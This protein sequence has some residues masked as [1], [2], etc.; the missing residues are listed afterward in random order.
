MEGHRVRLKGSLDDHTYEQRCIRQFLLPA[1]L[2]IIDANPY[3]GAHHGTYTPLLRRA[4]RIEAWSATGTFFVQAL[5]DTP[6]EML[7]VQEI[8]FGNLRITDPQKS[9][10]PTSLKRLKLTLVTFGLSDSSDQKWFTRNLDQLTELHLSPMHSI[11]AKEALGYISLMP[12]LCSFKSQK[13]LKWTSEHHQLEVLAAPKLQYLDMEERTISHTAQFLS[14]LSFKHD[15]TARIKLEADKNSDDS[16]VVSLLPTLAQHVRDSQHT[17]QRAV[18]DQDE[19]AYGG[20]LRISYFGQNT[21][22]SSA[23]LRLE[24]HADMNILETQLKHGLPAFPMGGLQELMI[25]ALRDD[26]LWWDGCF[27]HF[28]HL[29]KIIITDGQSSQTFLNYLAADTLIARGLDD[30]SKL[31]FPALKKLTLGNVGEG[32][33]ATYKIR[34]ALG[35]RGKHGRKVEVFTLEGERITDRAVGRI[36]KVVEQFIVKPYGWIRRVKI[37]V[38]KSDP[39]RTVL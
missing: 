13:L 11:S 31:A 6:D 7:S 39:V 1:F 26:S 29:H 2:P 23:F 36:G 17:I 9:P 20:V 4:K 25:I 8:E 18:L 34:C 22:A 14:G 10:F 30:W 24:V 16:E 35:G 27:S 5:G 32:D 12:S 19:E 38:G 37:C 28:N 3:L 33:E 21:E 15:F